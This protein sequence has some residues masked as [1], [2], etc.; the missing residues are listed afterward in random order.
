MLHQRRGEDFKIRRRE[1]ATEY[2]QSSVRSLGDIPP[3]SWERHRT[4]RWRRIGGFAEHISGSHEIRFYRRWASGN[5]PVAGERERERE[6]GKEREAR[7][8]ERERERE[9]EETKTK[10][11]RNIHVRMKRNGIDGGLV[12]KEDRLMLLLVDSTLPDDSQFS[13]KFH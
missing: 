9:E 5:E 13:G 12:C 8:R 1:P 3:L 6:G 2:F 7:K 10:D 11:T 4:D